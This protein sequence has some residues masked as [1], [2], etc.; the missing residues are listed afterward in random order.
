MWKIHG[1]AIFTNLN[2]GVT[3]TSRRASSIE[4]RLASGGERRRE[5]RH[6]KSVV[7]GR[8]VFGAM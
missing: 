7:E 3:R 8:I 6:N 2:E 1:V 5:L 4:A